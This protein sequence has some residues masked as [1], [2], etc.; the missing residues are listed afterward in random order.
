MSWL[1]SATE[2]FLCCEE[3]LVL[4]EERKEQEDIF[5]GS[6]GYIISI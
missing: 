4:S 1:K 3:A 5:L 2:T 6:R